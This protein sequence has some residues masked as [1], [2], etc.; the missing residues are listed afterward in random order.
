[1]VRVQRIINIY[2]R[3]L[4]ILNHHYAF[5]RKANVSDLYIVLMISAKG[6]SFGDLRIT[7]MI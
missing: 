3:L 1:M 6:N 4:V 2:Q 7:E 5:E